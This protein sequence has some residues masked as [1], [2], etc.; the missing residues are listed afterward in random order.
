MYVV[1]RFFQLAPYPP[2]TGI[3][4]VWGIPLVHLR[5]SIFRP[6]ARFTKRA[7]DLVACHDAFY[8]LE[9][10]AAILARL[11]EHV[12]PGK[13]VLAISHV[14]NRDW[15]NLSSGAAMTSTVIFSDITGG[16]C[17]T[18]SWSAKRSCKV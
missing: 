13:G 15:P 16:S 10:K 7:F 14:H 3:D 4:D 12:A 9:P 5:R 18:W 6:W 11:R 1:P 2:S 17:G 8:F